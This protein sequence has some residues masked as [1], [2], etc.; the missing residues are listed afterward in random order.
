[1]QLL[2]SRD[3]VTTAC[4]SLGFLVRS[5]TGWWLTHSH[6]TSR[7]SGTAGQSPLCPEKSV[8][9]TGLFQKEGE[10]KGVRGTKCRASATPKRWDM[11]GEP[12]PQREA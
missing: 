6:I 7:D 5:D 2:T 9:V 11:G 4:E 1:M 10:K 8:P 3:T 12:L